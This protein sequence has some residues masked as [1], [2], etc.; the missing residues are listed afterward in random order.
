[1]NINTDIVKRLERQELLCRC[2]KIEDSTVTPKVV[3]AEPTK[4]KSVVCN[5]SYS[6]NSATNWWLALI[7]FLLFLMLCLNPNFE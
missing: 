5:Y 3:P 6:S 2:A 1:M 4:S 7:A